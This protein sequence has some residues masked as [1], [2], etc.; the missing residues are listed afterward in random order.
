M[1]LETTTQQFMQ[2]TTTWKHYKCVR[3]KLHM[4]WFYLFQWVCTFHM[5]A[6]VCKRA[7]IDDVAAKF[8]DMMLQFGSCPFFGIFWI[9]EG[10]GS[11]NPF[12]QKDVGKV[13]T[14]A[15]P[16]LS[17]KFSPTFK[18]L[19]RWQGIPQTLGVKRSSTLTKLPSISGVPRSVLCPSAIYRI[20]CDIQETWTIFFGKR[21]RIC[22]YN[23]A[24]ST[25]H[26]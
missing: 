7:A 10:C 21:Y 25:N 19:G 24:M 6:F 14:K 4:Y 1:F 20:N 17:R 12:M 13:S 16:E 5:F 26:R 2:H 18:L 22:R 3:Q 11:C 8:Y 15:H 9:H 23:V